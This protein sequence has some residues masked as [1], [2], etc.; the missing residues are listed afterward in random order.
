MVAKKYTPI[1]IAV[2]F[3]IAKIW[4]QS[5]YS[6]ILE[7]IKKILCAYI[8]KCESYKKQSNSAICNNM[9]GPGDYYA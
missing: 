8:M 2:L 4:K 3:T 6:S 5:K 7:W 9:D 1:L